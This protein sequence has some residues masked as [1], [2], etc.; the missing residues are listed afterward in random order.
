MRITLPDIDSWPKRPSPNPDT[1]GVTTS[2]LSCHV[3]TLSAMSRVPRMPTVSSMWLANRQPAR[4]S[5]RTYAELMLATSRYG[6]TSK[7]AP[8]LNTNRPVRTSLTEPTSTPP[9]NLAIHTNDEPRWKAADAPNM[10]AL[11][12]RSSEAWPG[13]CRSPSGSSTNVLERSCADSLAPTY[14]ASSEKPSPD[15]N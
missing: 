15:A 12:P 6:P 8:L 1:G 2:F 4:T 10:S 9:P 11:N 14:P 13:A 7:G 5:G 3:G